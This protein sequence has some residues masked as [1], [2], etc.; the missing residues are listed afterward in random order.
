MDEGSKC[1]PGK[2]FHVRMRSRLTSRFGGQDDNFEEP[3]PMSVPPVMST[4]RL[5]RFGVFTFDLDRRELFQRG[6]AVRL[7][8][9]PARVLALLIANTGRLVTREEIRDAVWGERHVE[10][11]QGLNFS[12]RQIREILGDR[13]EA[14][15]FIET[16]P[17]RGYRFIA[18]IERPTAA[19]TMQPTA[20]GS[21]WLVAAVIIVALA[22][23]AGAAFW[24]RSGTPGNPLRLVVLP[25]DP[26]GG[27]SVAGIF[28]DGVIDDLI[29][30]L[31]MVDPTRLQVIARTSAF[32]YRDSD[33]SLAD[34]VRELDIGYV[35]DGSIRR[36]GDRML[37]SVQLVDVATGSAIWAESFE[38]TGSGGDMSL[39]GAVATEV[40]RVLAV[41]LLPDRVARMNQ[42]EALP[43]KVRSDFLLGRHLMGRFTLAD[44]RLAVEYF[45]RVLAADG[46]FGP[47]LTALAEA[48]VR[49]GDRVAVDTLLAVAAVVDSMSPDLPRVSGMAALWLDADLEVAGPLL[50]EAIARAPG[51]AGLRHTHAFY[52]SYTGRFDEAVTEMEL[53]QRLDPVSFS[54]NAD[55][56]L[57]YLAAGRWAQAERHCQVALDM[58]TGSQLG[59]RCLVDARLARGDST[60]ALEASTEL[61]S[62]TDDTLQV[63]V[64]LTLEEALTGYFGWELEQARASGSRTREAQ[65]L[66]ALGRVEEA[67]AILEE[68]VTV[69]PLSVLGARGDVRLRSLHTNQRFVEMVKRVG[70]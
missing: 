1:L 9:Q 12:I 40:S 28:G 37:I 48:H 69:S 50:A 23:G 15:T 43:R 31:A 66:A 56:G 34:I 32:A 16:V 61:W 38:V 5:V 68:L 49:M 10:F 44:T 33:K 63:E 13:A 53:A 24:P 17:R 27:D 64:E 21:R 67:L 55:L 14:P 45:E 7:Q 36:D 3:F 20:G 8:P 30:R 52:L 25:L 22:I 11:D 47:A 57:I 54:V 60:G 35:I 51:N 29:T 41:E 19:A 18:S 46:T 58:R 6:V 39:Q 62:A 42:P 26:I 65:S 2:M 59:W 70:G 4:S